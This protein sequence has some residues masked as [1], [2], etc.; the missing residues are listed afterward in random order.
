MSLG[1]WLGLASLLLAIPLGIASSLLTT[2]LVAY[3]E[4]RK[5][6]HTHRT[7]EQ[8][9]A[10]YRRIEAFKSGS[11]DRYPSYLLMAVG[12]VT[13]AV[14]F[15]T[16]V[17]L[18]ALK[19]GDFIQGTVIPAPAALNLFVAAFVCTIF[20]FIFIGG[21]ITTARRLER[22]DQYKAEVRKKWGDDAI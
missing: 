6:L 19:Y 4:K 12:A 21:I 5:L 11:R 18:L 13:S 15:A 17:L 1:D 10:A 14:G 8:E 7:K 16:F 22:F 3:M 9:L 2:R 20:C